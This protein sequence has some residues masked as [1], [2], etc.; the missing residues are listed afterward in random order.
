MTQSLEADR[1]EG[2][3]I[4][5]DYIHWQSSRIRVHV[6]FKIIRHAL[7]AHALTSHLY[8]LINEYGM[9]VTFVVYLCLADAIFFVRQSTAASAFDLL[10]FIT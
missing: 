3:T 6:I 7:H 1:C 8:L 4:R 9:H 2:A 5:T 10:D